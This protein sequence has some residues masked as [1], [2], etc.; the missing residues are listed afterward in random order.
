M[1]TRVTELQVDGRGGRSA[2][3]RC[4]LEDSLYCFTFPLGHL[5]SLEHA[6]VRLRDRRAPAAPEGEPSR[7]GVGDWV[8]VRSADEI[9][10]TLDANDKLRGLLFMEQQ[11]GFCG[12]TYRVDRVLV[13]L[14]DSGR[15]FKSVSRT[16]SLEGV[17]CDGL[18]GAAGCGHSCALY[19]RDEWLEPSTEAEHVPRAPSRWARVRSREEL[20]A[21]LD[22]RGRRD[23]LLLM[24]EHEEHAGRRLPVLR[25]AEDTGAVVPAYK[26][27]LEVFILAGARC[28]G[29]SLRPLGRC[30]R[31][32]ALLWHRD[33]LVLEPPE[34]GH[35]L[36][37]EAPIA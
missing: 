1:G 32:C 20:R 2:S 8:R 28:G 19:F 15:T 27:P 22:R 17:T 18:D 7:F 16:V 11:W 5:R 4:Q 24:P 36:A 6:L 3:V 23:G 26:T 34:P 14:L 30:D 10:A 12:R 21:T 33:W 37:G 9:R 13:R 35:M 25:R 29:A 31:N